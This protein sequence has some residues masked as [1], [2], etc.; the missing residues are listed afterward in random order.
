MV[1]KTLNPIGVSFRVIRLFFSPTQTL[2][3]TEFQEL[4]ASAL[5]ITEV[6]K[7]KGV[8]HVQY[9]LDPTNG[10]YFVTRIQSVLWPDYGFCSASNWLSRATVVAEILLGKNLREIE[11]T[12]VQKHDAWH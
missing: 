3:D 12:G 8:C 9:A 10:K 5:K 6:L 11:L 4:R 7:I 1:P 2:T